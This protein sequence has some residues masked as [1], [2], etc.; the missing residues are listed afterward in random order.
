MFACF[1]DVQKGMFGGSDGR[2][3]GRWWHQR[4]AVPP[5]GGQAK[6]RVMRPSKGLR[7]PAQ[8]KCLFGFRLS[9][10]QRSTLPLQGSWDLGTQ[11][12]R[13]SL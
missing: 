1:G 4:A 6:L 9:H 8:Q 13:R 2:P 7:V 3:R 5:Q 10:R 12:F 11:L